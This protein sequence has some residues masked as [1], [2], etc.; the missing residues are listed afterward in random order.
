[1]ELEI[2][3]Q[4]ECSIPSLC[5]ELC[6]GFVP[7]FHFCPLTSLAYTDT[8]SPFY[9]IVKGGTQRF[10]SL[11]HG[12]VSRRWPMVLS[13]NTILKIPPTV[14]MIYSVDAR[15]IAGIDA[16]PKHS[17]NSSCHLLGTLMYH[18]NRWIIDSASEHYAPEESKEI[19]CL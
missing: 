3:G 16:I 6:C 8:I 11:L 17:E 1:M 2:V 13:T 14:N 4:F 19:L 12:H 18:G 7:I 10:T 15:Q 9:V 5:P